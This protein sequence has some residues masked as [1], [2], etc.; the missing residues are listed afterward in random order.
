MR[1]SMLWLALVAVGCS[2]DGEP[3]LSDATQLSCPTPGALPFRMMSSGFQRPSSKAVAADYHRIKDEA[4]ETI[5]NA[6]GANA[7]IYALVGEPAAPAPIGYRGVKARTSATGGLLA[8]PLAG[9]Y[10]SLWY[11]DPNPTIGWTSIGRAMTDADGRYDLSATNYV[12]ANG[13][14]LYALLEADGSCTEHHTFLYGPGADV[15]ITDI[16]GTLTIN[17]EELLKSLADASYVPQIKTGADRLLKA[18]AQ[19][20]YPIIYLT[21]RPHLA[22]TETRQWLDAL[23]FPPGPV[24]TS[25][26]GS[27]AEPYKTAWMKRMIETLQWNPVAVYGNA[28]TDIAAYNAAGVLKDRTYI[29]GPLAGTERTVAIAND[30]YTLHIETVVA[31]AGPA[32]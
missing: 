27:A 17:D 25:Y 9:E 7:S 2:D 8:M 19:K 10:V 12:G 5:G 24:I 3:Q 28:D 4:S 15:I 6:G 18:W 14:P 29:I 22:R 16:D 11:H 20:G 1:Y 13:S 23:G 26:S 21:A 30:D 32:Q 31:S